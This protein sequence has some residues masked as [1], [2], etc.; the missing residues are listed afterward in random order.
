MSNAIRVER[1]VVYGEAGRPLL[2]DVYEPDAAGANGAAVLLFHGGGFRVGSRA[3]MED[4]ATRLAERGYLA[5]APEYRL[6]AEADWPAQIHDAKSVVRWLRTSAGRYGV[7]PSM[8]AVCGFSAGALA[9]LLIGGTADSGTLRGDGAHEQVSERVAAVVAFFSPAGFLSASISTPSERDAARPLTHV[10]SGFPPTLLLHGTGDT[11][12]PH[13]TSVEIFDALAAA[14]AP[15]DL[16]L[17]AGLPHEFVRL[18]GMLDCCV[19]DIDIFLRRHLIDREQFDTALADLH[20]WW[21]ER[22][23][24]R[25]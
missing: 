22:A 15:V 24:A 11:L 13:A 3:T 9:S 2:C 12:V 10:S 5:V 19:T 16:R 25:R 18:P 6:L 1:D 7:D 17:Y 4:A 21:A 14:G 20:R 23:Q 8:I